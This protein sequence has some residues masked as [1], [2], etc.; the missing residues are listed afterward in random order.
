MS[1]DK[2]RIRAICFDVDGTLRD[3]D[4]QYAAT[5]SRWLRRIRW[6]LPGQDAERA[7]RKLVMMA[8]TP[9]NAFYAMLDMLWL[10]GPLARVGQNFRRGEREV[11]EY[12]IIPGVAEAVEE[13]HAH[14]PLSVVSARGRHGTVGFLEFS[15]LHTY[16]QHV[17][18]AQTVTRIKPHP[19]PVRHAAKLM[20]FPAEN[21]L[22]VGDTV[23]D[24]KSGR[25]AGAQ[26]V[27]VLSGFGDERELTRAGADLILDSV[28]DLP[29]VL[30][31]SK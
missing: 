21:C 17:V 4:D 13:L 31:G 28:A 16:F 7:A 2:S 9:G 18:T 22:M 25:R 8:E 11:R 30:L 29:A 6:L 23:V 10:D 14:Y 27:G 15:R 19:A 5:F 1:L 3:T 12:M 24:I 20:A 26:T